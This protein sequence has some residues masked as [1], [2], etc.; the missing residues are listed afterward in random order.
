MDLQSCVCEHLVNL[1]EYARHCTL[2]TVCDEAACVVVCSLHLRESESVMG[3][4]KLE[5]Q[6]VVTVTIAFA[7]LSLK[8][9]SGSGSRVA[10]AGE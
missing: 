6:G 5:R 7:V 4:K 10:V 8:P 2:T 1:K 3:E 9:R